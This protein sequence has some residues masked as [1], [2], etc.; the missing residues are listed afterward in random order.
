LAPEVKNLFKDYLT[1][2]KKAGKA[3][4][5]MLIQTRSGEKRI[6]EYNSSLIKT[7]GE[8][9]YINGIARDVTDAK[10]AQKEILKLS[11]GV[12][13][14]PAMVVITDIDGNIEFIN[15]KVTEF[16]G[17]TKEE[18][19]GKNPKIFQSGKTP[20]KT[21]KELWDTILKGETWEGEILNK[22]KSGE[23]Y[24]E[25][26]RISPILNEK[27][28]LINFLSIKVDITENIKARDELIK[29][30]EEAEES[31]RI[32]SI[33]LANM[34]HELRTPMVGIMGFT[35]I[36]E[37]EI[38]N[39]Q[40]KEYASFIHGA[41]TRL[42]ETLN[43]ILNLT[44]IEAEKINVELSKIDI[45]KN[46]KRTVLIFDKTAGK[47]NL[48]LKFESDIEKF[49]TETDERMFDQI[50]SNLVNNAVKYTE[51]GGITVSV[52]KIRNDT[53]LEIKVKD[54][55]IG[56]PKDKQEIIWE[57][58]RQVSEGT[59]RVYEGTGLGLTITNKF[60]TKLGGEVK[61]ESEAGKGS[62]F[63]V[64]LPI[65]EKSIPKKTEQLTF[66]ETIKTPKTKDT[67][68]ELKHLLFVDDD[69]ITR[70][71]IKIFLKK[72]YKVDLAENGPEAIE[73]AKKKKYNC[74]L[75]D[76]NLKS[77]MSGIEAAEKIKEMEGYKEAPII[78]VTA[79][80]MVGDRGKYLEAGFTD[81]MSKPFSKNDIIELLNKTIK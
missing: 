36:L 71:V 43:L 72:H 46:I 21:Y 25:S 5:F 62:T 52:N 41:S 24:W 29:A 27:G 8:Y 59:S 65:Q 76:I 51:K 66:D 6:W 79:N 68:E 67:Q 60:V 54:T 75:M 22:R 12:E 35:E 47:K 16:T 73:K 20:L 78:A 33:F 2:I 50:I 81:Y 64:L 40:Q 58:F 70:E 13:Q 15:P 44:K 26:E 9:Q 17:Y 31:S 77:K 74:I 14:S 45:I 56:I 48:Y 57:D 11:R 10:K 80:A 23:M 19:I 37:K 69:K 42:M 32:K 1:E 18:L 28:E 30:K 53:Y 3:K 7:E 34:S 4:G 63:T 49:E 61:L 39:P 55:G 38:E